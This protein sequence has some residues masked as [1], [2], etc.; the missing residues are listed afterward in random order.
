MPRKLDTLLPIEEETS[1]DVFESIQG[2][3]VSRR[4]FLWYLLFGITSV[5]A[6]GVGAYALAQAFAP[7]PIETHPA[8]I[9]TKIGQFIEQG[10]TSSAATNTAPPKQVKATSTNAVTDEPEQLKVEQT[11]T[12]EIRTP[13]Q[14]LISMGVE[15]DITFL[16][17]Q[18]DDQGKNVIQELDMDI[19]P[20][21]YSQD[22]EANQMLQNN[23]RN[24]IENIAITIKND[25]YGNMAI[26]IHSGFHNGNPL[27]GENVRT[28]LQGGDGIAV[29]ARL[30]AEERQKK[31]VALQGSLVEVKQSET[32]Q[33]FKVAGVEV[34]HSVR[35]PFLHTEGT[36]WEDNMLADFRKDYSDIPGAIDRYASS[37][38]RTTPFSQAKN[39]GY[40]ILA[41][42][43]W[44]TEEDTDSSSGFE[45]YS[46]EN[47]VLLLEVIR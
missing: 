37:E 40:L 41:T 11:S 1:E 20:V 35:K 39:G 34:V 12:N 33:F 17:P 46:S 19:T 16:V 24:H 6:S 44:N 5:G 23:Y 21:A 2:K 43:G 7:R 31:L 18:T 38:G 30:S 27:P 42:S 4:T 9:P 36:V 14:E 47:I 28:F 32:T 15:A 26:R 29:W 10:S 45:W 25:R 22:E 13:I 3:P 8:N